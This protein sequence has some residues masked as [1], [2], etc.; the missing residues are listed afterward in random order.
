ME[1]PTE[2]AEQSVLPRV[3][4]QDAAFAVRVMEPT[5]R[6]LRPVVSDPPKPAVQPHWS[7]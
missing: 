5:L 6:H 3:S 7:G 4:W 1:L 2:D